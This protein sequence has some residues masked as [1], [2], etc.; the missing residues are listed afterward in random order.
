MPVK[1]LIKPDISREIWIGIYLPKILQFEIIRIDEVINTGIVYGLR[2][3]SVI[4][5]NF[6]HK[7]KFMTIPRK[8]QP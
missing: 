5:S 2:M 8:I 1:T 4:H 7:V 3:L 6:V